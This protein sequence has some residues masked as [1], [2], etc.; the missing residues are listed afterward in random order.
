[1]GSTVISLGGSIIVP[2]EIN[3][4]FL[5][6]FKIVISDFIK[7]GN[8]LIIVCGG[9]KTARKYCEAA[10]KIGKVSDEELDWIGI[11]AT[12]LNA[13]LVKFMFGK[14]A[15]ERVVNEP[16]KKIVTDKKITIASGW[17]PGWSTDYDAVLLAKQFGAKKIINLS[18]I[19]YVYDKDPNR[20]SSAKKIENISWNDF[21]KIV[22]TRW[23]PGS[24]LPFDPIAAKLA[25]QLKLK[26]IIAKG[27]DIANLKKILNN[28]KFRGTVI[29]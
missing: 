15:Y 13:E 11:K 23:K 26:V 28:K 24:N 21:R 22:G 29:Q 4:D 27:T 3:T 6:K 2:D 17:K 7:K 20:F 12:I 1:M 18:N 8:R 14:S 10:K 19:E 9:G 5:G 16:N 25:K